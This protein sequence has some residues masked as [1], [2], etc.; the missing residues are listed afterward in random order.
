MPDALAPRVRYA[1]AE[2]LRGLGLAAEP[3]RRD[4]ARLVVGAE[5][6][7]RS[8]ALRLR[9][10]ASGWVEAGG[11]MGGLEVEGERW[12]LPVG[13]RGTPAADAAG[14]VDAD[15]LGS[16]FW[17]LA[18]V[19]E[20]AA[21][22]RDAHG[23]FP[24]A[25]SL[26]AELAGRSSDAPGG[27]LRP[28][29]DA[30][31]RWLG[32]ALRAVGVDVPGRAWGGAAWALALTHDVDALDAGRLRG[33]VS[34][35]LRGRP[36][37]AVR[38]ALGPN[39]RRASLDALVA[40]ARRHGTRSTIY[41]KAGAGTP[42][43]VPYRLPGARLRELAAAGFEIGLHPSYAAAADGRRLAAER[44]RLGTGLGTAPSAVRMHFLRWL[45][46]STQPLLD[47]E[48]FR[49]DSSLGFS[50]APGFRRGTAQPFRLYDLGADRVTD[51]WEMP[52]AV[53][54]TTLF[55]HQGLSR[56]GA[57]EALARACASAR[58]ANGVAVVLWHTFVGGD[59][60]EWARR[61]HVL[62]R[63]LEAARAGGA[64]VGTVGGLLASWRGWEGPASGA[65]GDRIGNG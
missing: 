19:Q 33:L 9:T 44:E 46:G 18:G 27:P 12:P 51:L 10:D 34:E 11:G 42:H 39:Q 31:R 36:G 17:W 52:L 15:V 49:T 16:A 13:P 55:E 21:A 26:Q 29:V 28:A 8:S 59:A 63:Q 3:V 53:M 56:E 32:S 25:A 22:E 1:L 61:A 14:A 5:P 48:G 37:A 35:T 54:D 50:E 23:R 40:L 30:Y 57:A 58:R 4:D 60:A 6:D 43:D 41:V 47:A 24:Y 45:D 7:A 62:D 2:L 64:A 65:S 38:R 20:R